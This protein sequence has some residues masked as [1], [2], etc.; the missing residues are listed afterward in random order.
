[1][2]RKSY[3]QEIPKR[4]KMTL[5]DLSLQAHEV[6]LSLDE[7]TPESRSKHRSRKSRER[8]MET[9]PVSAATREEQKTLEVEPESKACM[10]T[11]DEEAVSTVECNPTSEGYENSE[12]PMRK[13][14][15][16]N[17]SRERVSFPPSSP[18]YYTA[19]TSQWRTPSACSQNSAT[20]DKSSRSQR[21]EKIMKIP[22]KLASSAKNILAKGFPKETSEKIFRRKRN[23]ST[24]DGNPNSNN[25]ISQ[26]SHSQKAP[27]RHSILTSPSKRSSISPLRQ[28]P[29]AFT[30]TAVNSGHPPGDHGRGTHT[31]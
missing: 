11:V 7:K 23:V 2:I 8:L 31:Q 9:E 26:Q 14:R 12:R 22:K 17:R 10:K 24:V 16:V 27:S 29:Q 5:A 20:T 19:A 6:P 3:K 15:R 18:P 1:M 30:H 4:E 28:S 25:S 13:P 21:S